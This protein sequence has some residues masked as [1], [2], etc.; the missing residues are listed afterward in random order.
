MVSPALPTAVPCPDCGAGV[1]SWCRHPSGHLAMDLHQQRRDAA[2]YVVPCVV[3]GAPAGASCTGCYHASRG[4]E[5]L[6]EMQTR[7]ARAAAPRR[8]G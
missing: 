3:C 5:A 4:R 2:Y 6:R 7:L 8:R 1:G